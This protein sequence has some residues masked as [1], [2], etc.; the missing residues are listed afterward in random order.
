MTTQTVLGVVSK[1]GVGEEAEDRERVSLKLRRA[2][3]SISLLRIFPASPLQEVAPRLAL[4]NPIRVLSSLLAVLW[5]LALTCPSAEA[6]WLR[7]RCGRSVNTC[8][9][10]PQ[11]CCTSPEMACYAVSTPYSLVWCDG[12]IWQDG[13]TYP[14]KAAADLAGS[15]LYNGHYSWHSRPY[16]I[17]P[18]DSDAP[19]K[20]CAKS[21][22]PN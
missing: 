13:G 21:P 11:T 18:G 17:L 7:G 20:G 4:M 16:P 22:R 19:G 14:N 3:L 12:N 9:S 2:E 8:N 1:D 5:L 6:G 10:C 15:I